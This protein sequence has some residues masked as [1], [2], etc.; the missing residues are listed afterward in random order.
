MGVSGEDIHY[1]REK[2]GVSEGIQKVD[3]SFV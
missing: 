3:K 2:K 1:K